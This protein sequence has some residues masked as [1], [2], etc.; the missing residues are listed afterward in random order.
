MGASSLGNVVTEM[1]EIEKLMKD[2]TSEYFSGP[3]TPDGKKTVMEARYLEL[4]EAKMKME[5]RSET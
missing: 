5:K 2:K 1:A 4:V 3:K